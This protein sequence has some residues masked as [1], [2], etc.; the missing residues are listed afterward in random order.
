MEIVPSPETVKILAGQK[1]IFKAL[2]TGFKVLAKTGD[3]TEKPLIP[4]A[5]DL[6]LDFYLKAK[7]P[8]FAGYTDL[9]IDNV[10]SL[11][12]FTNSGNV[13]ASV[14]VPLIPLSI[15]ESVDGDYL[16]SA[17]HAKDF[18]DRIP[19]V[20]KPGLFGVIRIQSKGIDSAR[21]LLKVDGKLVSPSFCLFFPNASTYWKYKKVSPEMEVITKNALPLTRHGFIE[22]DPATDLANPPDAALNLKYPNPEVGGLEYGPSEVYSVIFI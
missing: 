3:G 16:L 6:T 14:P 10:P 21:N 2:P 7:D 15:E 22:I 20:H 19:F 4:I 9:Q 12:L 11:Y 1:L 8:H 13:P 5:D 18:L 17:E